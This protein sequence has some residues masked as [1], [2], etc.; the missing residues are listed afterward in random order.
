MFVS[1]PDHEFRIPH[2]LAEPGARYWRVLRL[3]IHLPWFLA[4][5][6]LSE[7][8]DELMHTICVAWDSDLVS[9]IKTTPGMKLRSLLCMTPG[10]HSL[11]GQWRSREVR[12]IWSARCPVGEE[13]T[14]LRDERGEEFIGSMS[15]ATLESLKDRQLVAAVEP[16]RRRRR[17]HA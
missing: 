6:T 2:K 15:S 14:V 7:E 1:N 9:M 3:S 4:T 8:N 17:R 5:F 13:V 10:W 16:L 11:D 12:A